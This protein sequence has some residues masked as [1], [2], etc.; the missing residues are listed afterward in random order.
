MIINC[1]NHK[2]I[3]KSLMEKRKAIKI[4]I[5]W[6]KQQTPKRKYTLTH[7]YTVTASQNFIN[8]NVK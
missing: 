5:D 2:N 4:L 6:Q 8:H 7:P 3:G 1:F